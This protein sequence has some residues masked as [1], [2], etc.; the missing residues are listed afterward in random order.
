MP[1]LVAQ[2]SIGLCVYG[3][4]IKNPHEIKSLR[5]GVRLIDSVQGI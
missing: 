5:R 1:N 4:H 2:V 3:V